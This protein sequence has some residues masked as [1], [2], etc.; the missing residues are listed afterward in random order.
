MINKINT[1]LLIF[2]LAGVIWIN[3]YQQIY[4]P[5]KIKKCN[6]ISVSLEKI[7]HK[8]DNGG[9]D[10]FQ[11]TN[12]DVASYIKNLVSCITN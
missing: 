3:Y 7:R 12:L 9:V 2:C 1:A 6:D 8:F 4:L 10:D 5:S 11:V